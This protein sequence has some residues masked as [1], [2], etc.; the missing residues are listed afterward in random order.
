MRLYFYRL[1]KD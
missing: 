1:K